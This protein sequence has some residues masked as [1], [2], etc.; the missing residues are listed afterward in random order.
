MPLLAV[1]QAG[2]TEQV[3]HLGLVIVDPQKRSCGLPWILYGLTCFAL[4]FFFRR[5]LGPLWV[6][7]VTQIPAVAGMVS[8]SFSQVVPAQ[9][10]TDQSFTHRHLAHQIMQPHR[11]AFGVGDDAGFDLDRQII[12]DAY[13][14]GSDNLKGLC[15]R[16][17]ASQGRL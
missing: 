5:C 15:R 11:T 7:G 13:T 12:T 10:R 17:Q 16:R 9:E 2:R 4:F 8:Q 3:R 14:R 6:G 1:T